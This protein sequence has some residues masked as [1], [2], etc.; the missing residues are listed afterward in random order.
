MITGSTRTRKRS[1]F[2]LE[3]EATLFKG[4]S[5]LAGLLKQAQQVGSRLQQVGEELKTRRA[6]GQAGGGMVEV[7]VNGLGQILRLTIDPSL[8]EMKDRELLEDLIPAAANQALAKA[9]E[10]HGEVIKELAG[11]MNLPGLDE[12][13]AAATAS[14][15]TPS[16]EKH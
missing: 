14:D 11:G 15:S 6:V 16:D 5:N 2:E 13:L 3:T 8:V 4:I 7:E 9:K 10:L 1:T 12:A